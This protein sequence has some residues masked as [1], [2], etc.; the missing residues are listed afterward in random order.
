MLFQIFGEPQA[1]HV[2]SRIDDAAFFQ[3]D[4]DFAV[5]MLHAYAAGTS[6]FA[7][8]ADEF[9]KRVLA[10][11]GIHVRCEQSEELSFHRTLDYQR[12]I[13]HQDDKK[14]ARLLTLI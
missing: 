4:Y 5:L 12:I 3:I 14:E 7:E 9:G 11:L 13:A 1:A 10:Q 8:F 2:R 6:L